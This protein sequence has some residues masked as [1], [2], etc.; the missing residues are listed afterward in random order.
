MKLL[1]TFTFDIS[2]KDWHDQGILSRE[3]AIYKRM[4]R[5]GNAVGILTYGGKEDLEYRNELEGIELFPIYTYMN[6]RKGKAGR[7]F[8]SFLIPFRLSP[9]FKHYEIYK[10]NQMLGAWVAVIAKIIYRKRLV[11]R[12]GYEWLRNSMRESGPIKRVFIAIF[13][14]IYEFIIYHAAS[15]IVVSAE[16][17][18]HFIKKAFLVP[19]KRV[20]SIPNF[21]NTEAFKRIDKTQSENRRALYIGRLHRT[22]NLESLIGGVK[23][24]S[25]PIGLDII[26]SGVDLK[27]LKELAG[28]EGV[29]VR[30]LGTIPNE[31]LAP[32]INKYPV[33][34]LVSRF[35]NHPKTLLEAMACERVVV[36]SDV[37]GIRDIIRN[38]ISG[39]LVPGNADG[40]KDGLEKA[41][42]MADD[43]RISF[44]KKAREYVE[45]TFSLDEI[46]KKESALYVAS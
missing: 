43:Q 6:R 33:F 36:G 4:V 15:S 44:G 25:I 13:G 26:G 42:S 29:D 10:T 34:V 19:A 17:L 11:V 32:I 5:E 37:E 3:L 21:V 35:E 39:I 46:F 1:V 30:F 14:Y 20:V 18:S 2:L 9:I 24:A 27:R 16:G 41:F 23:K 38:D 28:R 31:R 40:I 8:S 12:C 45:K 22:K 7:F